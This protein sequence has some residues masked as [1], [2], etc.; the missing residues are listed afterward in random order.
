VLAAA[1]LQDYTGYRNRVHMIS[2][3]VIAQV[4]MPVSL[5]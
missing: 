3:A 1:T 4:M 2:S 5:P